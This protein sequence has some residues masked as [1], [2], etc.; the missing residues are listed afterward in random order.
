MHYTMLTG[1]ASNN[2]FLKII[3]YIVKQEVC[4]TCF[5]DNLTK[6]VDIMRIFVKMHVFNTRIKL[7]KSKLVCHEY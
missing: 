1:L 6:Q 4:I 5:I 7:L 3:R 2:L